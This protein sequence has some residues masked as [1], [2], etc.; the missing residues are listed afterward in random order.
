MPGGNDFQV[1]V[2]EMNIPFILLVETGANGAYIP[3]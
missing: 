1:T 2:F 3:F